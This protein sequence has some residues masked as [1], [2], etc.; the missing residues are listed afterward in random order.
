MIKIKTNFWSRLSAF[1]SNVQVCDMPSEEEKAMILHVCSE[2]IKDEY[3]DAVEFVDWLSENY[4][5]SWRKKKYQ[6]NDTTTE[7]SDGD[8]FSAEYLY[9]QFKMERS[10]DSGN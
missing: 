2:Q 3:S 9:G 10:N 7:Y 8:W 4:Y 6:R 5:Y 1:I